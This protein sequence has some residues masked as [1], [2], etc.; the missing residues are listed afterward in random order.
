MCTAIPVKTT[1]D[2]IF[3][4]PHPIECLTSGSTNNKNIDTVKEFSKD[5]NV[6][7]ENFSTPTND[8]Y[9]NPA[10][11]IVKMPPR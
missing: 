2:Q 6:P 4:G 1:G 9:Y 3:G 7:E 5:M 8:T 11:K 10:G